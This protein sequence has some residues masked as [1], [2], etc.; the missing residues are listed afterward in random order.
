[1]RLVRTLTNVDVPGTQF[2]QPRDRF[3]L[4]VERCGRQVE[5]D[6]VLA[7]LGLRNGP[8]HDTERGVIGWHETDFITGL[9]VDLPAQ[10]IRPEARKTERIVRI[11]AEGDKPRSHPTLLDVNSSATYTCRQV[12][13]PQSRQ[14]WRAASEARPTWQSPLWHAQKLVRPKVNPPP[15]PSWQCHFV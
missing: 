1:M 2:D 3:V 5:M 7:R 15:R 12:G 8:E 9:A 10:S 11:E 4:I 13:L 14:V 6:A